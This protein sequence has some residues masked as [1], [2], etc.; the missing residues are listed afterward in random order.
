MISAN[1]HILTEADLEKIKAEWFARGKFE[2]TA[3]PLAFPNLSM[4][5]INA[6]SDMLGDI[7]MPPDDDDEIVKF[8]DSAR[9]IKRRYLNAEFGLADWAAKPAAA[10]KASEDDALVERV[11]QSMCRRT[12]PRC[13]AYGGPCVNDAICGVHDDARAV[14]K[15]LEGDLP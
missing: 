6:V 15:M 4:D 2:A 10:P 5:R 11:S 9:E 3:D 14:L 8:C 12:N 1:I 13:L 7:G